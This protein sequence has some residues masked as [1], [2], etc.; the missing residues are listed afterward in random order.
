[1]PIDAN[2]WMILQPRYLMNLLGPHSPPQSQYCPLWWYYDTSPVNSILSLQSWPWT[3]A[4]TEWP[5]RFNQHITFYFYVNNTV[6]AQILK[7]S[8]ANSTRQRSHIDTQ[9]QK[10]PHNLCHSVSTSICL[11]DHLHPETPSRMPAAGE[12]L[13]DTLQKVTVSPTLVSY[14]CRKQIGH[15]GSNSFPCL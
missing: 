7:K 1:M 8:L 15:W 14:V 10:C 5:A 2:A 13:R 11:Q 9:V 6:T 12:H 4:S 3:Q